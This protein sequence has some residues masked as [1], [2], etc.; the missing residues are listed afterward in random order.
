MNSGDIGKAEHEFLD[1]ADIGKKSGQGRVEGLCAINLAWCKMAD[2]EWSE[3]LEFAS[4]A[5]DCLT[6]VVAEEHSTAQELVSALSVEN[7]ANKAKIS[8][9]LS[10]AIGSSRDNADL[11]SPD[12]AFIAR[13]A[14]QLTERQ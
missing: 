4:R 3:A 1:A 13:V 6:L 2:A 5:A 10:A 14:E 9:A 8:D 7:R 11:Y 12:D